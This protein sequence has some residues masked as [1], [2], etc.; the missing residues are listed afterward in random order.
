MKGMRKRGTV[1]IYM[2]GRKEDEGN[3]VSFPQ[4]LFSQH[5]FSFLPFLTS[6]YHLL[7]PLLSLSSIFTH[8]HS[9]FPC[10]SFD[11]CS[12]L[13]SLFLFTDQRPALS[14]FLVSLLCSLKVF[15]P[16]RRPLHF[17]CAPHIPF[18]PSKTPP[19]FHL[20]IPS[21]HPFTTSPPFD[22][23]PSLFIQL[24]LFTLL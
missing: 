10:S 17:L 5:L 22:A 6:S 12:P 2:K 11:Q 15:L 3:R 19:M 24:P 8:S 23:R 18:H 4:P 14:S 13:S 9:S 7:T 1:S 20:S 16:A 21:S